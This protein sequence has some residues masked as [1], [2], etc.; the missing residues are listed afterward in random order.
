MAKGKP[1][2]G[3]Q[4]NDI[5]AIYSVNEKD[6]AGGQGQQQNNK[7]V[8]AAQIVECPSRIIEQDA[9]YSAEE[10]WGVGVLFE[11]FSCQP[12]EGR[13]EKNLEGTS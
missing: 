13:Y 6:S 1:C 5:P 3:N 11:P 9:E 8:G 7:G 12:A 2:C 4:C 10:Q